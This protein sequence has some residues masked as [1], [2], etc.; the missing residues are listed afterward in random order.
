MLWTLNRPKYRVNI[1]FIYTEKPKNSC[2]CFIT[3]LWNH[4][5]RISEGIFDN[6]KVLPQ[7]Y[8]GKQQQK[9]R[10]LKITLVLWEKIAQLVKNQ[11]AM[12]ET[13]IQFLGWEDPLEKGKATH[14]SVLE[15]PL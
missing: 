8:L 4:T 5:H 6:V 1:T 10:W 14:S 7:I 13:P 9:P 12:W 2:D 3:V 15:L 11:P